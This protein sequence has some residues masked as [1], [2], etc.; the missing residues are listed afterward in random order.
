MQQ[1]CK[2]LKGILFTLRI[3]Q[4]QIFVCFHSNVTEKPAFVFVKYEFF[5]VNSV[6]S[7]KL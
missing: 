6:K 4:S 2:K 7:K 5:G 1:I 3:T